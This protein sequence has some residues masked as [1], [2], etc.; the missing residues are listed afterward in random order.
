MCQGTN[1]LVECGNNL[2]GIPRA[3]GIIL[4]DGHPGNP[5]LRLRSVNPAVND[6]K[7]TERLSPRL[8]PFDPNNGYNPD[9]ASKYS[10]EFKSRYFR[11]QA[12]RMNRL[13]EDALELLQENRGR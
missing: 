9:G 1:K 10:E 7:N 2:A 13:I 6:E 5:I 11:A 4:S 8:D 12:E 3:D